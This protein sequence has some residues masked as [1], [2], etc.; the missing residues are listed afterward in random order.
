[1]SILSPKAPSQTPGA[2]PMT[3]DRLMLFANMRCLCRSVTL[4]LV[5]LVLLGA[6]SSCGNQNRT[7]SK[8]AQD[9]KQVEDFDSS[10]TFN[11]LTL[12]EYDS[13]GRLWW[14]MKSEQVSY[15]KDKKIARIQ[16]PN[17]EFFQDGKAIL[18]V[19]AKSGEVQ[20][21]GQTIF[22]R[23]NITATDTRDG[24][25]LRGNELEWQ[26]RND[27]LIVRD[28]VTGTH[29]QVRLSAKE[30]RLFSRA[31]RLELV[32]QV[33][34]MAIEPEL[35]FRSERLVWQ[36]EQQTMTSDRAV[37]LNRF[38]NKTPTDRATA[39][40]GMVNLKERTANLKQNAEVNFAKPPL[41]LAGNELLWSLTEQT[42]ISNQPVTVVNREQQV[43]LTANK[44]RMDLGINVVSLAGDVRGVGAR[45]QSQL[46]SDRLNWNLSNQQF[47]AEGNVIYQQADPPL[48]LRGPRASGT[49]QDQTVVVSGGRVVT[50]FVP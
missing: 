43:T 26:P 8:I 33:D 30:G 16:K 17:G 31:R 29:R 39:G 14:K 27:V 37:Q 47:E 45:N 4:S 49:L 41:Q 50:E 7:A 12:E 42:V 1:M 15:S 32:G 25:V 35:Q 48:N 5:L 24:L 40:Q 18:K 28:Q 34:A 38:L 36:I 19:T 9:T 46:N 22:L 6:A 21:D 2:H 20:Q 3:R 11:S 13:K 10:L 44:G 23:G